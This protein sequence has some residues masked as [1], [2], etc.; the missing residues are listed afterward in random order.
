MTCVCAWMS[1]RPPAVPSACL[2]AYRKAVME[3]AVV[4]DLCSKISIQVPLAWKSASH[5]AAIRFDAP[6]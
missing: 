3:P 1:A 2:A 4:C 5:D 6:V